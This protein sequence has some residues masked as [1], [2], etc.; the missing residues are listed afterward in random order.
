MHPPVQQLVRGQLLCSAP[1]VWQLC[2]VGTW[3]AFSLRLSFSSWL[4][5]VEKSFQK[6]SLIR[7]QNCILHFSGAKR[8][9]YACI[10][11]Q[12]DLLMLFYQMVQLFLCPCSKPA[13]LF[14]W[15]HRAV[16]LNLLSASFS[17]NAS[18]LWSSFPRL[19][20]QPCHQDRCEVSFKAINPANL[21]D[22]RLLSTGHCFTFPALLPSEPCM[23]LQWLPCLLK[24]CLGRQQNRTRCN[25]WRVFV[26]KKKKRETNASLV[27]PTAL[28]FFF[29]LKIYLHLYGK[30]IP[31]YFNALPCPTSKSK[32]V[33]SFYQVTFCP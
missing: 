9:V 28:Y 8:D 14:P 12:S 6:L 17:W 13:G 29:S 32:S 15:R 25:G 11:D 4:E 22:E 27:Q 16:I 26:L 19:G 3:T 33:L 18:V 20:K 30:K 23:V 24:I 7:L 21:L 1:G 2:W 5:R 31:L 10:S